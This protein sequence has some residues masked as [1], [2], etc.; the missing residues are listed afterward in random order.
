M[1]EF[2]LKDL[3]EKA[4]YEL[5]NNLY[6]YKN[7]LYLESLRIGLL[8]QLSALYDGTVRLSIADI[9]KKILRTYCTEIDSNNIIGYECNDGNIYIVGTA[10]TAYYGYLDKNLNLHR[11]LDVEDLLGIKI[12]YNN[13][14]AK[15]FRKLK[16]WYT[17]L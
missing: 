3:Y 14:I 8:I 17:S 12:E 16:R 1:Q 9:P 7:S 4:L 11:Y 5:D 6:V 15:R 10:Y 2:D 13:S